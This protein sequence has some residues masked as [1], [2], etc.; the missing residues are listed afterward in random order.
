MGG[1][2]I[3]VAAASFNYN[4]GAIT[5]GAAWRSVI[6]LSNM[7]ESYNVVGPGQSGHVLSPFYHDQISDWTTGNYHITYTDKEKYRLNSNTLILQPAK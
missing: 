6:D 5:H 3:T 1:S 4:S 2:G 7:S